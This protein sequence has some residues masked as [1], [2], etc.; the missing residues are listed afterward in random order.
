MEA[1]SNTNVLFVSLPYATKELHLGRLGGS[2]IPADVYKKYLTKFKGEDTRIISGLDCYGTDVY[3]RAHAEGVTPR[4]YIEKVKEKFIKILNFFDI[5]LQFD[6]ITSTED[7]KV[8]VQ[9]FIEELYSQ[10]RLSVV[11]K[12]KKYCATCNIFLADRFLV[13]NQGVPHEKLIE[14]RVPPVLPY[15]CKLCLNIPLD[16]P[17]NTLMLEYTPSLSEKYS[18]ECIIQNVTE[19][20]KELSRAKSPWGV[21]NSTLIQDIL[22][23]PSTCYVWI[24][25]LLSYIQQFRGL[26]ESIQKESKITYFYAK[27]NKYYHEI[28]LPQLIPTERISTHHSSTNSICRN[29]YLFS[30]EK[31]SSSKGN[32]LDPLLLGV[33]GDLLRYA[34]CKLDTLHS[35]SDINESQIRKLC[36]DYLK[37]YINL[38]KRVDGVTKSVR[39]VDPLLSVESRPRYHEHMLNND[40]CKSLDDIH[41]YYQQISKRIEQCL[42]QKTLLKNSTLLYTQIYNFFD[43]LQP[44]TPRIAQQIKKL[45]KGSA[46][47]RYDTITFEIIT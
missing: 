27:D 39:V 30:K 6:F 5:S 7:H 45:L 2:F 34:I 14:S 35:D 3:L 41:L 23:A 16:K 8:F 22:G 24:E 40:L 9:K 17:V 36:A 33:P 37:E 43:Y 46:P 20:G 19:T 28:I 13:D 32:C 1:I 44:F 47:F 26:P 31:M 21:P 42:T 29:Y 12:E 4:A 25:A 15:R 11:E 10:G 18:T 38:I